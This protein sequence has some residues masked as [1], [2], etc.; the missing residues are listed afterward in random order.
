MSSATSVELNFKRK[1]MV[2]LGTEY[3][4]EMK[5][6]IFSVMVRAL[7]V[8]APVCAVANPPARLPSTTSSRLSSA[9]SR[10]TRPPTRARTAM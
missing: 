7:R 3:A 5:K 8:P 1:E 6:G 9:S 4:G 2:I 10:S